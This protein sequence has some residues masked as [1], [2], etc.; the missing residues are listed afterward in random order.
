[1]NDALKKYDKEL[2]CAINE[3]LDRERNTLEMIASE[4]F[5]SPYVLN[6]VGSVLTNKYAEGYPG[7]RYY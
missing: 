5:T 1:M 3:E 6:V 4:N 2:Y 7:R